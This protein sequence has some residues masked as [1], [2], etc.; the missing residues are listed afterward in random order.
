[1]FKFSTGWKYDF[2]LIFYISLHDW[3]G[4]LETE[5]VTATIGVEFAHFVAYH[6]A[7]Y[8]NPNPNHN[9]NHN[10]NI[11]ITNTLPI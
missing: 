1:M 7:C 11:T 6:L 2:P 10:H 5:A 9:H 4:F 3:S 8:P